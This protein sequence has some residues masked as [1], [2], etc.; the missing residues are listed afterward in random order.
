MTLPLKEALKALR[1]PSGVR[2][3]VDVDAL[4]MM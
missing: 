4:S 2:I 1:C 3:A